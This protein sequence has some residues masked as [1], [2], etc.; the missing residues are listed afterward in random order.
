MLYLAIPLLPVLTLALL[1]GAERFER[2]LDRP[3]T[4][5]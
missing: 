4:R 3:R 5:D 2:G 1:L